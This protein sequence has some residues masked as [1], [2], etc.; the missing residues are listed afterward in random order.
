MRYAILMLGCHVD[1]GDAAGTDAVQTITPRVG[2]L[3]FD[4]IEAVSSSAKPKAY[5]TLLNG[6]A[7]IHWLALSISPGIQI[8]AKEDAV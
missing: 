3:A 6:T 8:L 7:R 1:P 2:D 5:K 4:P